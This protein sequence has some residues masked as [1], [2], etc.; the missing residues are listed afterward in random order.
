MDKR[1]R[2]R[3]RHRLVL[4]IFTDQPCTKSEALLMAQDSIH[5]IFYPDPMQ[6]GVQEFRISNIKGLPNENR[7][8]RTRR[9]PD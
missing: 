5:G 9:D 6:S 2:K 7:N 8:L 1:K 4:T 3:K